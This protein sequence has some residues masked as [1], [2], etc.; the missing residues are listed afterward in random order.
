[1]KKKMVGLKINAISTGELLKK[2]VHSITSGS[3]TFIIDGK[4]ITFDFNACGCNSFD[5]P[6]NHLMVDF[7][8]GHSLI[9]KDYDICEDFD[10]QYAK[11]GLTR[12]DITAKF[13][14]SATNIETIG[15][16]VLNFNGRHEQLTITDITFIDE[17]NKT[18]NVS[19]D[20]I[21]QFNLKN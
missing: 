19:A 14:A 9:Y 4:T 16:T 21:E 20:V 12:S 18:Y 6:E 15:Y 2:H 5:G 3:H 10:D 11:L 7:E 13:L 8:T 17:N 1:M